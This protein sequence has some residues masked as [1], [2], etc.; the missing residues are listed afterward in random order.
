[1]SELDDEVYISEKAF[2]K[3]TNLQFLRLYNHFPDEA[4]KLQ[5]PHGLDYLPRK[6]RLLH[7]DSYPIKCMPS[8]FRP[9]FLVELTL[10]DSKLVKL[11]EGVQVCF[12]YQS[13]I[14]KSCV[15]LKFSI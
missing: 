14:Q 11:W 10:R 15:T 9:E 6:L 4:V 8:K 5:L 12:L 7:R 3:M 1:M 13:V 2:K